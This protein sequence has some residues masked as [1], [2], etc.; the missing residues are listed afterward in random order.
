MTANNYYTEYKL[1][2][3]YYNVM[4]NSFL[5]ENEKAKFLTYLE[6]IDGQLS[7][8]RNHYNYRKK[9]NHLFKTGV[10]KKNFEPKML[11]WD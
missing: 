11:N 1:L 2:R 10:V 6:N 8:K 4:L 5:P 9:H 3:Q 7:R